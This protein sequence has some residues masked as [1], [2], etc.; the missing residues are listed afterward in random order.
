MNILKQVVLNRIITW[1]GM[2]K[3]A[4]KFNNRTGINGDEAY[5]NRTYEMYTKF[6]SVKNKAILELGPGHT[7][8]CVLKALEDG[9]SSAD[10][11]DIELAI[12]TK[13]LKQHNINFTLYDGKL[14]P[15]GSQAFDLVWSHTVYEHLR[16]PEITVAETWRVLKPGGMAIHWIDL[17]DH[18]VLNT[19][20]PAVFNML[21]YSKKLWEK[22]T[23]NRSTYVNRLRFS[24]W[25]ELHRQHGFA[26]VCTEKEISNAVKS[27]K[28][29]VPYLS[30]MNEEDAVTA[31][32]L[33]V[34]K[35]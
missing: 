31:Q 11:A 13:I 4:R 18:F 6:A 21:Q 8:Q 30:D 1:P 22:M 27:V 34:I 33:L 29:S 19:E 9:A 12:D 32:M 7:Y 2:Q 5:V 28:A 3:I 23:W 20:D 25:V 24:Q 16:Y 15:Y 26:I 17:R 10:I 35:K 14:L